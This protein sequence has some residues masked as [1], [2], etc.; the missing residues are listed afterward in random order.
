MF[1][2]L[3]SWRQA[4]EQEEAEIDSLTVEQRSGS[5]RPR[6]FQL[7]RASISRNVSLI[8]ETKKTP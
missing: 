7:S 8:M 2:S 6:T 3:D 4:I 1:W 5:F